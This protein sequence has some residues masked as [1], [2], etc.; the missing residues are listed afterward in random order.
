MAA[1]GI[2]GSGDMRQPVG[3]SVMRALNVFMSEKCNEA[4]EPFK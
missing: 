2:S 4:V 1:S 3:N